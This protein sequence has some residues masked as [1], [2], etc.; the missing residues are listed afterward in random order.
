MKIQLIGLFALVAMLGMSCK[1][2]EAKPVVK[3]A[4]ETKADIGGDA[5]PCNHCQTPPPKINEG[6]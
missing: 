3:A 5:G 1:K 2:D 4:I 6:S